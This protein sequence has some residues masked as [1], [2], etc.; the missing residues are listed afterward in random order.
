MDWSDIT[1][2][3]Q[4]HESQSNLKV[5]ESAK[6]SLLRRREHFAV[7][8]S[9]FISLLFTKGAEVS[10]YWCPK[11]QRH[12]VQ[13]NISTS[14][15]DLIPPFQTTLMLSFKHLEGTTKAGCKQRAK[16]TPTR[17]TETPQLTTCSISLIFKCNWSNFLKLVFILCISF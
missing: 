12:F 1:T 10:S 16:W 3:L 4:E 9:S 5:P 11:E 13:V 2:R 17:P 14:C 6:L 15:Q 8:F 7:Y